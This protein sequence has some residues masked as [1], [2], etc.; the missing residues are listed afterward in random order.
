MVIGAY[1]SE[2][3]T[4]LLK[5]FSAVDQHVGRIRSEL[6]V[7]ATWTGRDSLERARA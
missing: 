1:F 2:V 3:G 4:A 5:A 6:I 7:K